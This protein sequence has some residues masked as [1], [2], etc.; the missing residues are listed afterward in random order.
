MVFDFEEDDDKLRYFINTTLEN[1]RN[2]A[3]V[4]GI[5]KNNFLSIYLRW[6]KYVKPKIDVVIEMSL[7]KIIFLDSDFFL[8]DL[9]VDDRNTIAIADDETVKNDFFVVFEN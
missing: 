4:R 6:V 9:F 1:A 7:K 8:A 2:M 3:K 5:D